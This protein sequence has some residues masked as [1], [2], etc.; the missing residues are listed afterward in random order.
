MGLESSKP[1]LVPDGDDNAEGT[2]SDGRLEL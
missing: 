1:V 2:P